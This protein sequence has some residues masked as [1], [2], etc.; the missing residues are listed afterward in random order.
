[1]RLTV[2]DTGH[3]IDEATRE[4]I[5]EPYFTTKDR[6][7][8]SGLGLSTVHGI[9]RR[10]GGTIEVSSSPGQ[11]ST[12]VLRLPAVASAAPPPRTSPSP[13]PRLEGT[14]RI[15]LVD[16]EEQITSY[17]C[18]ALG[19]LGYRITVCGDGQEALER[20]QAAPEAFDLVVT[21]QMMPRLQGTALARAARTLRPDLPVVLC[22]GFGDAMADLPGEDHVIAEVVPKPLSAETLARSIRRILADHGKGAARA[23]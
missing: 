18:E 11:G 3:G 21:D 9:V 17:L 8:G 5:F 16:D 7:E 6:G 23:P 19:R 15:L 13:T 10:M 1:V 4:R 20:L 14:E 2:S 22:S 12:F